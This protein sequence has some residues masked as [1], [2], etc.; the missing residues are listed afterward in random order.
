MSQTFT[1]DCYAAAHQAATDLQSFENNFA[2]LKSMFSGAT[3]P[4]DLVA[5]MHWFDT[6]K[7]LLKMRNDANDAWMGIM[8]GDTSHKIW[9]YRNT[10]PD[11]W[12]IDSAVTDTVIA[13]KGGSQAYNAN[14]GTLAGTWTQPDCTLTTAQLPAHTHGEAAAHTHD[15]GY[16]TGTGPGEGSATAGTTTLPIVTNYTSLNDWVTANANYYRANSGGAHTHTSVGSG[17]AHNHGTVFRPYAAVGTLQ[18]VDI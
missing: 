14:G 4:A 3:A 9:V 7:K 18:Y 15:L 12:A 6:T 13:L 11:G 2:A 8:C 17:S 1:D 5:G 16:R 10:A